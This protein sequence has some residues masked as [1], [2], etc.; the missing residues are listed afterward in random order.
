M[1]SGSVGRLRVCFA[2]AVSVAGLPS[3]RALCRAVPVPSLLCTVRCRLCVLCVVSLSL[4]SLSSVHY[5]S[6]RAAV[7]LASFSVVCIAFPFPVC[8]SC[9]ADGSH[10]C[11][12]ATIGVVLFCSSSCP[13]IDHDV[14]TLPALSSVMSILPSLPNSHASKCVLANKRNTSSNR[15]H[16]VDFA[17]RVDAD[18]YRTHVCVWLFETALQTVPYMICYTLR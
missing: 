4:F 1:E 5:R 16:G 8:L 15:S 3:A 14:H 17:L 18:R 13:H 11:R 2:E 10:R 12:C 7:E 6:F 9:S